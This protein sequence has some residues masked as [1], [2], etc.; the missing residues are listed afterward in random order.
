MVEDF[1]QARHAA[2]D[3]LLPWYV[4]GTLSAG[5]HARVRRHLD[6]CGTCRDNVMLLSRVES[7]VSRPMATPILPSRRP[8]VLLE[9]IDR[10]ERTGR[11]LGRMPAVVAASLAVAAAALAIA[12]ATLLLESRDPAIYETVTSEPQHGTMDYVVSLEFEA[13]TGWEERQRV[14]RELAARDVRL[15]ETS[16]LYE[17]KLTLTASTLAELERFTRAMEDRPEVR[18]ARVVALQLPVESGRERSPKRTQE[19]Q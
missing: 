6:E 2:V 16:G 12:A 1:L 5:E 3:E 17:L 7:V 11:W 8:E 4:N 19:T 18:S 14:L 13:D 9:K 10:L 15:D